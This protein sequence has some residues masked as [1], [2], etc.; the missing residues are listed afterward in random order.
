[1]TLS[2]LS[3]STIHKAT[4]ECR[5]DLEC[6]L[7]HQNLFVLLEKQFIFDDRFISLPS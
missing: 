5:D 2:I 7:I 6:R 4:L 1:M 3:I